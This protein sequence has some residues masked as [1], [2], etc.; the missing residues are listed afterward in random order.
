M[1]ERG[2]AVAEDDF[3]VEFAAEGERLVVIGEGF[4][5]AAE[6]CE[7]VAEVVVG[8]GVIGIDGDG[9]AAVVDGLPA[10]GGVGGES[11][12]VIAVGAGV[13][14]DFFHSVAPEQGFVGVEFVALDGGEGEEE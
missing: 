6:F 4:L 5:E 1:R 2:G 8:W 11:V 3:E 13:G 9:E 10:G 14:G 12:G 7:G